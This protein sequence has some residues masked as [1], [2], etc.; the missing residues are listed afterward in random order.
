MGE[1]FEAVEIRKFLHCARAYPGVFPVLHL[2][3]FYYDRKLS[4]KTFRLHRSRKALIA[5][6]HLPMVA[7]FETEER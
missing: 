7:E 5:S 6:D 2:D 4:L 3:H 1:K